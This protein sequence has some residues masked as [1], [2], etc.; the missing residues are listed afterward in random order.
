[1]VCLRPAAD[2]LEVGVAPPAGLSVAYGDPGSFGPADLADCEVLVLASVGPVLSAAWCD[3]APNLRL[4]QFTGAGTDRLGTSL[5]QRPNVAVRNVPGANAAEV[6]EYV[7]FGVGALLR[8]LHL[9][10]ALVRQGR[11]GLARE[12]LQP[13]GIHSLHARH[14][15]V[16]GLGHIGLAVAK[17]CH[18]FGARVSYFDPAISGRE[19]AFPCLSLTELLGSVDVLTVHVPLTGQTR[20]LLGPPEIAML[21]AGSILVNASRGGVVDEKALAEALTEGRLAGAVVDVY[22]EEPP[23]PDHPLLTLPA[24]ISERVLLTPHIAGVTFEAAQRLYE[25][26]WQ[27]VAE[28]LRAT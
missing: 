18:A 21:P 9:A 13:A 10:D 28:F 20:G 25:Q 8:R 27:S 11:Y 6:A 1:M 12:A 26:A 24:S 23:A 22:T 15:G 16:V 4:V 2:F 3:Q 17:L 5:A 7:V 14:V 19:D